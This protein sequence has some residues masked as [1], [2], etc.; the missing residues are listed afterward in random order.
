MTDSDFL[1]HC[2][3]AS[4]REVKLQHDSPCTSGT[5]SGTVVL[6]ALTD[7]PT[8]VAWKRAF[9]WHVV[10]RLGRGFDL[11]EGANP[12]GWTEDGHCQVRVA[13][14]Q[15][16]NVLQAIENLIDQANQEVASKEAEQQALLDQAKD[17]VLKAGYQIQEEDD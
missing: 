14:G 16:S 11:E 7:R 15:T 12:Y 3:S 8:S 6:V 13:P 2:R 4:L 9:D 5:E 17:S 10:N 1:P